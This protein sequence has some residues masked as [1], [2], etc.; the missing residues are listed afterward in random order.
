LVCGPGTS[1][2]RTAARDPQGTDH[3]HLAVGAFGFACC[4]AR[5]HRSCRRLGIYGIGLAGAVLVAAPGTIYLEDPSPLGA[6]EAEEPGTEGAHAFYPDGL[7]GTEP[8]RPLHELFVAAPCRRDAQGAEA[9]AEAIQGDGDME[10]LVGIHAQSD[11]YGI[12]GGASHA[13][14]PSIG[15]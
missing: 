13:F 9:P 5:E 6:Q 12:C 8:A 4:R 10:A 1:L 7:Q 3:F 11:P 14:P 2:H 15:G